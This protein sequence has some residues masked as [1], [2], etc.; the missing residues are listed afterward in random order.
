MN[1][2]IINSSEFPTNMD[3]QNVDGRNKTDVPNT[4]SIREMDEI[5]YPTVPE[6][7]YKNLPKIDQYKNYG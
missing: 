6:S 4:N 3:S 1:D 2:H 5:L 7:N